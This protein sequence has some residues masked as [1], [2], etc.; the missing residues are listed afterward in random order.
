MPLN[1][2]H[3]LRLSRCGIFYFRMR[4]PVPLR[5][6]IGKREILHS[7]K[8]RSPAI[9]RRM[10]YNLT[11]QTLALFEQM[12]FDP[13]KFNPA[14]PSTFPTAADRAAEAEELLSA[15]GDLSDLPKPRKRFEIDLSRGI[16]KSDTPEDYARMMEALPFA[17]EAFKSAPAPA[18]AAPAP[19]QYIEPPPA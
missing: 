6:A 2:A 5:P 9:A 3:H 10:A 8:T 15:L 7:L 18:P 11:S 17:M 14:D 16:M 4:V 12:T 19:A 1:L 13:S